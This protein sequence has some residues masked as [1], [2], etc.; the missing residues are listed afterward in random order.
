MAAIRA[1][2]EDCHWFVRAADLYSLE[3]CEVVLAHGLIGT[4]SVELGC[5]HILQ[6]FAKEST[7]KAIGLTLFRTYRSTSV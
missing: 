6:L 2:V 5:D 3:I 7:I 4:E 1:P